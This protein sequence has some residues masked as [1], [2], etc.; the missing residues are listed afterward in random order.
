[1]RSGG[2]SARPTGSYGPPRLPGASFRAREPFG[3]FVIADGSTTIAHSSDGF[4]WRSRLTVAASVTHIDYEDGTILAT[5]NAGVGQAVSEN[6]EHWRG[7]NVP[8]A[9]VR[10]SGSGAGF[11]FNRA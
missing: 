1:M 6:L 9:W 8:G 7:L 4:N 11:F 5:P 3:S 10:Y 2:I